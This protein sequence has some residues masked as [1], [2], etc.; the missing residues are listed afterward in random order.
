MAGGSLLAPSLANRQINYKGRTTIP[1]L[2]ACIA[3]ASGGLI[4]GYDIGI[5]GGV[6]AMDDFL[7]KFFPTVYVRKH[8]AHENNYCKYDNQGLQAFTSSLYLAALF[9]S[10]GASYVTSNK[11]RRPT[12]LIG[13]LSFLVGA[14]LNAAA[15]NLAML[16]IGRMMLGVGVGFGNQSV[17]VYLSEMAPPKLR[18]GLNIM[19]QQ[20][21]NFGILCANLINYGTA[22]LQPWGWR[23]SL[24][25][26]AVPASLLTLAAIF[27][28]DTPN[29][30]IERG[31]LEQGKSVLQKIRGTPDVEAEFQD[32]VEASRVASTIKDPFLSIFRRK[33]RPQLTM[34]VLIPY[35]QQVTGINVITFYAPVLFQSIGFHSN[36]SLYSAVI[37]GL[38]LIIGTGISIF[39]VDKFG[40]RVLFLH[41]GILMFIGQV[42]TGLVLA[43][44]FNGNEELS[45]GFAVVILVVTCV[46]VVSFAWSWGPLG[47]LVPSEVFALETRSAGQCIT[48]AVNMLFT[49]AVAQS[50]LSMFCHFRFGIFLFFAGWVVVMTLFV[51][52]FLPETKKVPI[53]EMQQEWSKH[54]YWRRFAQ[55]QENQDDSK[56]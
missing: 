22:N 33:N 26:A 20:A 42:V 43:F 21:V 47:W 23:L 37:T 5:S 8:A 56:P 41:G 16:I 39:T 45:R 6:I 15:E 46:Y 55:E 48:V 35:F 9:A 51:H 12:M 17:P 10:F 53:E 49:F 30:L 13:G 18:G 52:F 32:L 40:R 14:A 27:L 25:L 2:L 3:A 50:F 36:A 34:A 44:E 24:G 11:G 28:S 38:M 4:F 1:V 29:S 31:H 7:I 54:W 19:F